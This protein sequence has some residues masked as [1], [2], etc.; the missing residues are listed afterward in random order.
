MKINYFFIGIIFSLLFLAGC[1]APVEEQTNVLVSDGFISMKGDESK[2]CEDELS[3]IAEV[4]ESSLE[5][6][7]NN[8]LSQLEFSYSL[9]ECYNEDT[10]WLR[11]IERND[12]TFCSGVCGGNLD[13][14]IILQ[15]QIP[16]KNPFGITKC[17]DVPPTI[18][19]STDSAVCPPNL[20]NSSNYELV[21]LRNSEGILPGDY[22]FIRTQ[23][24]EDYSPII[25]AFKNKN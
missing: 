4:L 14:C 3:R 20:V 24:S 8:R 5:K 19:F 17:L 23:E 11:I 10:S 1:S 12:K 7:A 9:P 22:I 18:S 2:I 13:Q 25:C 6:L 16:S 15:L 21:D